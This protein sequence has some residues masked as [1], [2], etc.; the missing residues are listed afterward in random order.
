MRAPGRCIV[1]RD[2]NEGASRALRLRL[3]GSIVLVLAACSIA[4][5][6]PVNTVL[7]PTTHT[8]FPIVSGPHAVDCNTCHG[9]YNTFKDFSCLSCHGHEDSALTGQLHL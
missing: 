1:P 2:A 4:P 6:G 7:T 3:A 8:Y 5:Q 9:A